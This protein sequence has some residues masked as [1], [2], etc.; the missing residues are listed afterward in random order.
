VGI[1]V[2]S[3]DDGRR[4]RPMR[5]GTR[6]SKLSRWQAEW[7][8]DALGR[9]GM[10]V[11]F[12]TI[13]TLGDESRSE[14]IGKLSAVGVFTKALQDALLRGEIDVAVHSLKDLP[15]HAVEG[16]TLAAIP[17]RE[18]NRDALICRTD[19]RL[20]DLPPGAIVGTGSLR[21]KA[22]LLHL[23]PDLRIEEIR[24]NLDTRLRKLD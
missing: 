5:I 9:L 12:V 10:T 2:K 7:V 4:M 15:T 18:S 17:A 19:G 16:L 6:G 20:M 24:G 3:T 22:Q 13:A 1:H 8:G 23:R 14:P 11:E 21:R